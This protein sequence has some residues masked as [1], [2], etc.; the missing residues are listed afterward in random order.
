[1]T[2]HQPLLLPGPIQAPSQALAVSKVRVN[3]VLCHGVHIRMRAPAGW[4]GGVAEALVTAATGTLG[5]EQVEELHHVEQQG[6]AGHSQHEDDEDG[7]FS[8]PG[9]VAGHREWAG[10]PG[11]GE[12]GHH[13][14]AVE[15]VLAH[16]EADLQEDLEKELREVAAQQLSPD[17]HFPFV[18]CVLGRLH[19]LLMPLDPVP[20]LV[21]LGDDV[22]GVAEVHQG[23]GG[24]KEDLQHPETDVGNGE[25]PVIAHVLA[26]RL[27][28]VAH[29]VRV[30]IRPHTLCRGS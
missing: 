7:L 14:E 12:H 19:V 13:D 17:T 1:M 28:R 9:H 29:H 10:I 4:G 3:V 27:V 30:F 6:Q 24:H 15:V 23:R 22:H 20:Q 2:L 16:D 8:R 11:A 21:L 18:V 25:L 26:T 5:A